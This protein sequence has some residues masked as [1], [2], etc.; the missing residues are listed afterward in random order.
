MNR[1]QQKI[2]VFGAV[3][4][5]LLSA[6]TMSQASDVIQENRPCAPD[7]DLSSIKK[8]ILD[9]N[10]K[11]VSNEIEIVVDRPIDK[12]DKWN[13]NDTSLEEI[14]PGIT[15]RVLNDKKPW[16]E[17]H[18]RIICSPDGNTSVEEIIKIIPEK[19]FLYK[20]WNYTS[21]F[22]TDRV[23]Y[24]KGEFWYTPMGNKTHIRW[25]YSFKLS[26]EKYRQEFESFVKNFWNSWMVTTLNRMKKLA[27]KA[28]R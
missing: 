27:E 3:C 14:L 20:V 11:H 12:Y 16:E 15:L 26:D 6:F 28:I 23:E 10:A 17:G 18:R 7:Y 5:A 9:E 4:Y 13:R 21:P 19:Y 2:T 22:F 24:G 1:F 25:R 8:V